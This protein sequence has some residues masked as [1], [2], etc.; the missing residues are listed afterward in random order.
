MNRRA[1]S[2]SLLALL[3]AAIAWAADVA[4]VEDWSMI[5]VGSRGIPEGW[6]GQDWG[7][8][9]YDMTVVENSGHRVLHLKS[10]DEG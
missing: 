2:L 3:I 1:T 4:V 7:S 5:P 9:A 8:P 10:Q 6:R